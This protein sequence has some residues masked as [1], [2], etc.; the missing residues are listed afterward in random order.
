MINS[1]DSSQLYIRTQSYNTLNSVRKVLLLYRCEI[2]V[3]FLSY[4]NIAHIIIQTSAVRT[5]S[6]C[7]GAASGED[8]VGPGVEG[9][10]PGEGVIRAGVAVDISGCSVVNTTWRYAELEDGATERVV[11]AT[12]RVVDGTT[13]PRVQFEKT[14]TALATEIPEMF[15][16]MVRL[17]G[18]SGPKQGGTTGN[19][20][21]LRCS[22]QGRFRHWTKYEHLSLTSSHRLLHG[23][24]VMLVC[25]TVKHNGA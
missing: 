9:M 8:K 18:S 19:R 22:G 21:Q 11:D 2:K 6:A 4:S 17:E 1:L 23:R 12:E 24:R 10:E 7:V 15:D 14:G 20:S 25:I 3:Y 5:W 16:G 13:G